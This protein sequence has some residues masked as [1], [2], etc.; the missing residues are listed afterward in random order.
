MPVVKVSRMLKESFLA[1]DSK[2]EDPED[3][4]GDNDDEENQEPESN[5]A[6]NNSVL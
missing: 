2:I 6:N 4:L 5:D 3:V 1:D